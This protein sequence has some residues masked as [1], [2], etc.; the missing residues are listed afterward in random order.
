MALADKYS[1][2]L[3]LPERKAYSDALVCLQNLPSALDSS[4]Y[5]GSKTRYDDFV[6][7]HINM[8]GFIH[9]SV[10]TDS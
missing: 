2:D 7:A 8:T 9:A 10:S 5:P 4:I 6:V 3:S 1:R